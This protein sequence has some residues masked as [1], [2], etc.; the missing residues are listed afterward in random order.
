MI[1]KFKG[2][3]TYLP[4]TITWGKFNMKTMIL[5]F[6]TIIAKSYIDYTRVDPK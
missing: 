3:S 1:I 6:N 4:N 5:W 2:M